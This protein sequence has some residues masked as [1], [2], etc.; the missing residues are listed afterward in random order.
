MNYISILIVD[1]DFNK[2]TTIIKTIREVFKETLAISQASCVQEAIENLQNKEFHLLIT[3]LQMPLKYD[4][5]PDNRGGESLIRSIYRSRTKINVP[6]YIV[7]LTQFETLK[8]DLK[9]VWKVWFYESSIDE[10]KTNLRDLIFHISLIKSR[11]LSDKIET[12]YVEGYIDKKIISTAIRHFYPQHADKIY[13]DM[14]NYGG[15]ASWVERQLFIWAKSLIQNSDNDK[16]LKAVVIFDN[17]EAGNKSIDNLRNMIQFNSAESKTFSILKN[18][19]RYSP[20]LKSIKSKGITFPTTIE[21]LISVECWVIAEKNGWLENRDTKKNVIDKDKIKFNNIN[22]EFLKEN[23]FTD[24]EILLT[25]K[26]IKSDF[27]NQFCNMVCESGKDALVNIKY[28]INDVF[29]R[30]NIDND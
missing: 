7:G 3:D 18:S 27:K 29:D 2:I 24:S 25:T 14:I 19:Y 23:D 6:I 21:D 10:W 5:T 26:K 12:L 16:Y 15:G 20:L 11:I 1:D 4:D 22:E 17:D 30:L 13:I 28:Q 9:G 8:N